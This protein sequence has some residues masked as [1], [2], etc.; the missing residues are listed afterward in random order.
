MQVLI[1][2]IRTDNKGNIFY[3]VTLTNKILKII[4]LVTKIM[5]KTGTNL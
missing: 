5:E 4:C 3:D 1:L 2:C